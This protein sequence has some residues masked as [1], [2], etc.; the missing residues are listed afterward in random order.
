LTPLW[1]KVAITGWLVSDFSLPKMPFLPIG[2][3][4]FGPVQ[5][6]LFDFHYCNLSEHSR[7]FWL[8]HIFA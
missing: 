6:G 8:M 3:N 2:P 4:D 5:I 1:E 7:K